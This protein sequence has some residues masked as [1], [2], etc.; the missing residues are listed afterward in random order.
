MYAAVGTPAASMTSL[1]YALE[2]SSCAASAVG[3]NADDPRL[4]AAVDEAGDQRDL[5]PDDDEVDPGRGDRRRVLGAR[6]R[7]RLAR[8]P[9]VPG[10][11]EHLR[12]LRGAQQRAHDGV[13][14]AAAADDED[15]G[16]RAAMK[17]SIGIAIRVS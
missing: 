12:R 11:A 5:R 2:P 13:L 15:A 6:E 9:R 16:Q 4:D 10:R 14:A 8:D 3:P 1:A 17:S 7:R